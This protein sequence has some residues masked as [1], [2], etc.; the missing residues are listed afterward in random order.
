MKNEDDDHLSTYPK[1]I[2]SLDEHVSDGTTI[3]LGH[4]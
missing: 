4:G 2:S 3:K 1:T